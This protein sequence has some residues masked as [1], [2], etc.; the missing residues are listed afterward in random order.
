MLNKIDK[1]LNN[2]ANIII[3]IIIIFIMFY[4]TK[5]YISGQVTFFQD[6]NKIN[7]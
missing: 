4:I 2:L 5:D 1:I 3:V 7:K 6:Y